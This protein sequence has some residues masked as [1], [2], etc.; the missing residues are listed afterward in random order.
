M[1]LTYN[2]S[3]HQ[4]VQTFHITHKFLFHYFLLSTRPYSFS[5]FT[6][7][8]TTMRSCI[9]YNFKHTYARP[10]IPLTRQ[11]VLIKHTRLTTP[12]HTHVSHP[13]QQYTLRSINTSPYTH[14]LLSLF[15]LT[16]HTTMI[17][18]H[19]HIFIYHH[20]HMHNIQ[21]RT[22]VRTSSYTPHTP[23]CTQYRQAL[24]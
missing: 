15:L 12:F 3:I 2:H 9:I 24:N 17:M 19:I 6:Y 18:P 16:F 5:T 23:K 4:Y 11:Y 13:Q 14:I 1:F 8:H 20:A 22:R 10:R 7:T 21:F